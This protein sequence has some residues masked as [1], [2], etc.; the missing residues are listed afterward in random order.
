MKSQIMGARTELGRM[1]MS[2]SSLTARL[3]TTISHAAYLVGCSHEVATI[4]LRSWASESA[5]LN[6]ACASAKSRLTGVG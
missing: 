4:S 5:L 6:R 3:R 2:K 1:R